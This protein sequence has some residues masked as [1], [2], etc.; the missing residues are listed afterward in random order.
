MGKTVRAWASITLLSV[1]A[2]TP[3]FA[4]ANAV[5]R[6]VSERFARACAAGDIQAVVAMYEDDA[7]A[8]WPGEGAEGAGKPAIEKLATGLCTGKASAPVL[9]SVE[10]RSLGKGYVVTHGRWELPSTAPDGTK[11]VAV[12]RTTEVLKDT[13]GKWRYVVDHAS[14]GVPPPAA[15]ANTRAH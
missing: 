2:A 14:V 1:A 3:A 4:D 15:P 8:V 13:G 5:A 10:G 6:A 11:T 12:V 9:K 7:I